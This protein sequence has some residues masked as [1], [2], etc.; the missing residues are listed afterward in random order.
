MQEALD[1]SGG[2]AL[3]ACSPRPRRRRPD[4]RAGRR[5]ARPRRA[6]LS[7][8]A[9]RAG[10][11]RRVGAARL[12]RRRRGK[13]DPRPRERDRRSSPSSSSR[14]PSARASS[15]RSSARSTGSSPVPGRLVVDAALQ[16]V[17]QA[18]D[19]EARRVL[20]RI[21]VALAAAELARAGIR[22]RA[23]R[24]GR[25]QVAVLAHVLGRLRRAPCT[26]RSTS[27]RARDRPRPARGSAAPPAARRARPPARRRPRRAAPAD[28]RCRCPRRR[29]RSSA[30]R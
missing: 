17:G 14:A 30:A 19:V 21:E 26:T 10:A 6:V 7:R 5:H 9:P 24:V 22:R 8:G 16:L 23:Q 28:R 15:S 3:R 2:L 29:A 11:R 27:A 12:A 18:V 13:P 4:V 20:V 25:R 1:V